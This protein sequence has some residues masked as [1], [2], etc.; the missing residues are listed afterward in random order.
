MNIEKS[1]NLA[2]ITCG[3]QLGEGSGN[4]FAARIE[5]SGELAVACCD[6]IMLEICGNLK[7]WTQIG[8]SR[9]LRKARC[10]I[11]K[12]RKIAFE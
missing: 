10:M 4:D 7:K 6:G 2:I 5:R 3:P 12:M 8:P 11:K 9:S 1:G